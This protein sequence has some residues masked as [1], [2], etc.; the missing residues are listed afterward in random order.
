VPTVT[1]LLSERLEC[2]FMNSPSPRRLDGLSFHL[3]F[4]FCLHAILHVTD[5][6]EGFFFRK[7]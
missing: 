6:I 4:P 1:S 7:F 2:I 3:S 5:G